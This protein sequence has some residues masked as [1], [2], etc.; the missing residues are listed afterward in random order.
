MR[1]VGS[2]NC[3]GLQVM[4]V[5]SHFLDGP[6]S[7][8]SE[9]E[10]VGLHVDEQI[11]I[12]YDDSPEGISTAIGETVTRSTEA[13]LRLE[14][15][16]V[17][18]LGDRYE[19]LAVAL[20][21][22]VLRIP[23][24]HIAGGDVTLGAYDEGFRHA[25]TKLSHIHFTTNPDATTRVRQLG[26][27][28]WRVNQ[29]GSPGIDALL[30]ARLLSKTE[31]EERLSWKFRASNLLVTLHPVTLQPGASVEHSRA[32]VSALE[33]L[34]DHVAVV[35]TG[36]NADSEGAEINAVLKD[37]CTRAAPRALHVAS[38]GNL[39][40][41]S[42]LAHVDAVVGNSSS[43]L[44]EAP[45]LGTP[46]V[47]I[48]IRQRGRPKANSVIHCDASPEA[49]FRSINEALSLGRMSVSNPYGDGHSVERIISVLHELPD[50]D[51]LLLK[52]FVDQSRV[53]S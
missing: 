5:G 42:V 2:D 36:A 39:A 35:I 12:K 44:Y 10:E 40:Y 47:D 7:T 43:G 53:D 24:A 14:P 27:E 13:L 6:R 41:L 31:L 48:G 37:Y 18:I 17:V 26:E 50:R 1:A 28:P 34:P 3:L 20:A 25:L 29:V 49:I 51:T 9:I 22:T 38:L 33:S 16:I 45:S 32:L 15:D 8:V 46:T 11:A 52:A 21:A 23:I 4:A 30:Q 19:I